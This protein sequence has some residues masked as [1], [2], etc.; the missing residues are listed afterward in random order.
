M[1]LASYGLLIGTF[2]GYGNDGGTGHYL[3]A[4]VAVTAPSPAGASVSWRCAVDTNGARPSPIEYAVVA[5]TA[6][7]FAAIAARA[8]RLRGARLH[9]GTPE[10]STSCAI[11]GSARP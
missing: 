6:A 8:G 11:R 5:V 3:H 4:L 7:A 9:A 10:H 1:P 2:A